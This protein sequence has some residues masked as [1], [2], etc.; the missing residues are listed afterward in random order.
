M[1]SDPSARSRTRVPG[2]RAWSARL[3]FGLVALVVGCRDVT[4]PEVR[5]AE[6]VPDSLAVQAVVGGA[7]WVEG[8]ARDSLG[9]PPST[10][11]TFASADPGVAT[12]DSLGH[13]SGLRAGRTVVTATA[14]GR[15]IALPVVVRL[16]R[17]AAVYPGCGLTTAGEA[18]CWGGTLGTET[19]MTCS[20]DSQGRFCGELPSDVP[21]FVATRERFRALAGGSLA[22]EPCGVA[23]DGRAVCWYPAGCDDEPHGR[24]RYTFTS[25]TGARPYTAVSAGFTTACALTADGAAEC[26]GG[27][28]YGQAGTG[29]RDTVLAPTPVQGGLQ[30]RRVALAGFSSCGVTTD[31]AAW[32]WGLPDLGALYP[33]TL[34]AAAPTRIPLGA[35]RFTDVTAAGCGLTTD[36]DVVCWSRDGQ[37][38]VAAVGLTLVAL[39]GRCGLTAAGAVYCWDLAHAAVGVP[40]V[41]PTRIPTPVPFRTVAEAD[42]D[43]C[44]LGTDGV[45]Y[46]AG[47]H[48]QGIGVV[49]ATRVPGQG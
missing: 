3:G 10:P 17:Y 2:D 1:S 29:T 31:G 33:P 43:V 26:W 32:C 21:T 40:R 12:V 30:F 16:V 27:N 7:A 23:P 22:D 18:L 24:C 45:A 6:A 41:A 42:G 8:P 15:Q 9:A 14:G 20:Y 19:A 4:S 37:T 38:T 25:Q 34:G 28:Y 47:F 11:V 36:G 48:P 39:S 44:G 46:C 13:V 35:L 49:A 5:R